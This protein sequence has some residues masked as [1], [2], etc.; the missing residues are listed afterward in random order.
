[1]KRKIALILSIVSLCTFV[2]CG[3]KSSEK[4][5]SSSSVSES[6][7]RDAVGKALEKAAENIDENALEGFE[8]GVVEDN[9]YSSSFS[10]ISFTPPADFTFSSEEDILSIMNIGSEIV[11]GD[12]ADLYSQLAKQTSIYDMMAQN[13]AT[14]ENIVIMYENL[15]VYGYDVASYDVDQYLEA[16]NTQIEDLSSSGLSY[17]QKDVT[18]VELGGKNFTK[19]EYECEIESMNYKTQ[20]A[21]Y[22]TKIDDYI[23]AI[24]VSTGAS[25][26]DSSY[27]EKCFSAYS[28][29]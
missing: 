16:V 29:E 23:M 21:Y 22:L 1:M 4:K 24:I 20:Q 15:N 3:E 9:V 13:N 7:E 11:G 5:N 18:Q 19:A 14:A 28:A 10:G 2:S 25:G 12:N 8:R 6:S 17:T 26:N 27:Y